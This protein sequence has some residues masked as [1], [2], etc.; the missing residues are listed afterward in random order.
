MSKEMKKVIILGSG[1][2][3]IG[4]AGEFDYSGSQAIKSLKEDGIKTVLVNPNIATVQTSENMA[5]KV[6]FLPV[7]FSFVERIIKK[8]KPDGILLGFGGQ[9]ALNVGLELDEKGVLHRNNVKVLGTSCDTIRATED[10]EIFIKKLNEIDVKVARSQAVKSTEEGLEAGEKI[11]F[12]LMIRAAYSLGG[13]GSGIIKNKTELKKRLNELFKQAPQ[14]LLEE[15]LLGWKEVEYEVVRDKENNCVTVCNMEN[16]DPM[17]IHTGESIVVAPSQTLNNAEYHGLRTVAQ[18]VVRHLEIIGECNIQYATKGG[19]YRVIEVNARLSRS[20]ALASKATGYPLAWVAAKLSLGKSLPE[21]VNS[22]TKST[23]ACFEPALDYVALKIPRWDLKKFKRVENRISSEMKSVGEVMALGRSFEEVLQ[24]ALRMLNVNAAGLTGDVPQV[25]DLKKEI[26]FATDKRIFAL[27]KAFQAN[28]SVNDVNKLSQIDPWFLDRI[29]NI[30]KFKIKLDKGTLLEAKKL[31]FSDEQIARQTGKTS[32]AVRKL[33][34]NFKIIPVVKQIDTLAGEFPAKTNYL[35]MTYHGTENDIK[36]GKNEVMVLG[37]GPYHIGSSVEFDWSCVQAVQASAEL[38]YKTVMINCNP[39]TVSTDYDICDRLYFEELTLERVLDIHDV[40]KPEGVIISMGGQV[41]NNLASDLDKNRVRIFGTSARDIDRA[42][43]RHKFSQLLDDMGLDQPEWRELTSKAEAKK[44]ADKVGYPVLIRPSYVLSGAAMNVAFDGVNLD[45]YLEKAAEVSKKYPVVISKFVE[46]ARE[47]EIDGVAQDGDLKIYALSEHIEK[48][49]VHSGDAHVVLPP[50]KTYLETIRRAK[51][52]TKAVISALNIT[53]PF[54]IQ[55]LAKNNQIRI[56]ELNL[57]ASRS[58]PFVSK[59][60][61]YNFAKL[62]TKAM[63]GEDISGDYNTL[64]LNYVGVK[65]PQ[66]SYSR[67]KGADP[68]LYV[69]MGSTGEVAAFGEGYQEAV[70]K[71]ILATGF[72]LPEKNILLSIG[73]Q[74]NKEDL[75]KFIKRLE[76]KRYKIYAT[77]HTSDFLTENKVHNQK[78]YKI[79]TN[80]KPNVQELLEKGKIDLIIN[81]PTKYNRAE[82]SD[83]YLIR[84]LATDHNISLINDQQIAKIFINGLCNLDLKNMPIKSWDEYENLV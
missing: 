9:T 82:I 6:Y 45:D 21:V 16:L 5:D 17:G 66:F 76:D 63:L 39:E 24:K 61:K 67:L 81:I 51:K 57:R 77:E 56:I 37:S 8:E 43:N 12:P 40:E 11:G 48:A 53:G 19:D 59:V 80:K 52:R 4:Q 23:Q 47:I 38:G 1:G 2:L 27:A 60:T 50:Q 31:G 49:G 15:S 62:A 26:K 3:K 55:F 22:V 36:R 33:R 34:K 32:D 72:K 65:S 29:K 68:V 78:V 44:F 46:G 70:M 79:Q 30:A 41:P 83:G 69:E 73:K 64:D 14:V 20:S 71:S 25:D 10:R 35:Y 7:E 42:E 28:M 75:L 58:L 13:L 18:K 74:E 84:R 54:N